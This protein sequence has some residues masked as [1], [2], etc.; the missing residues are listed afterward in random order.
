MKMYKSGFITYLGKE[1]THISS[2]LHEIAFDYNSAQTDSRDPRA[3]YSYALLQN[4]NGKVSVKAYSE[5]VLINI[6]NNTIKVLASKQ[7]RLM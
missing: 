6:K 2:D 7:V 5:D 4:S 1:Q 3:G